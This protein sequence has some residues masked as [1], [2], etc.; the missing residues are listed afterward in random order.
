MKVGIKHP[1]LVVETASMS[2]VE[3][4]D[5]WYEMEIPDSTISPGKLSALQ[6]ESVTYACQ[7]HEHFLPDESRA[8]FLVG[9]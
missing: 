5:V 3:P 6:L 2:S 7:Q 1:D 9:R 8:G 4:P